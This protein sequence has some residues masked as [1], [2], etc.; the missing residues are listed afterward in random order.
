MSN[1]KVYSILILVMLIWG[2]NVS[3]MKLIIT[4][5]DPLTLQGLRVFFAALTVFLILKL[6]KQPLTVMNMPWK[7]I[8]L[9]CFFGVI[10]HHGFFA[11]GIE[12]TTAMKTA[13]ISGMSPLFTAFVAVIFKDTIM[14]RTKVI[15]FL[16]GG[17]GVLVAIVRD[18]SDL[19]NWSLGDVYIFLSFFLQA[20][21]FIAIRRATRT[22]Q[23]ML[24]TAWILLIG[25]SILL[26][27]S[28]LINPSSF[29]GFTKLPPLVLILF[30][31]SA[32]LATGVGHT[33][34]NLCIK[35]IGAAE[36]AIFANFNTV[37]ALIFS[38]LLLG[39]VITL[40]QFIGSIF[41]LVGVVVGTGNVERFLKWR[42]KLQEVG[43]DSSDPLQKRL[44][45]KMKKMM[46]R[47]K[48]L[49]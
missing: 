19:L 44:L 41:I 8:L 9:G 13:I 39:E 3:W 2:M 24:V 45:S 14:T 43:V 33:L 35:Q 29:T 37:F 1:K 27:V 22:M 20:F 5:G 47:A 12:Q 18:F 6:M 28:L 40:Q 16:L 17:I 34:Y 11:Y 31:L 30:F 21:S 4:S 26:L 46:D 48:L 38:A 7:Y 15:G 42:R 49:K 23:P 10:C 36:S 32:I 25:S